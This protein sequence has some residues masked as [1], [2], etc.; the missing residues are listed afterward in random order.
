MEETIHVRCRPPGFFLALHRHTPRTWR[1]RQAPFRS[2]NYR[3]QSSRRRRLRLLHFRCW[4]RNALKPPVE[5]ALCSKAHCYRCCLHT[6]DVCFA[7]VLQSFMVL[8]RLQSPNRTF[9]LSTH[10]SRRARTLV[11]LARSHFLS[12]C[13]LCRTTGLHKLCV[14]CTEDTCD[15]C[16][17]WESCTCLDCLRQ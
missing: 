7:C 13:H 9:G 3:S 16:L 5:C 6:F 14:R 8:V 17:D 11:L 12:A 10:Q 2:R 4:T 15:A 1:K